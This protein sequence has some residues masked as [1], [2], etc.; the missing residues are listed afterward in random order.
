MCDY[1]V[2]PDDETW[3]RWQKARKEHKCCACRETIRK[4]DRYH[5]TSGTWDHDFSS[6]EQCARC[7]RVWEILQYDMNIE[8]VPFSL[9]CGETY[10]GD[11]KE[12]IALSFM[13]P[14]EAQQQLGEKT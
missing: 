1:A 13:T 7:R 12:L 8:C 4:G 11:N 9:D 3:E 5:V 10:E 6:H 2:P 14:D